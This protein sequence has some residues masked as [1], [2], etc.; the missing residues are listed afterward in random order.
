MCAQQTDSQSNITI[1]SRYTRALKLLRR[2]VRTRLALTGMVIVVG[3][4]LVAVFADFI[5]PHPPAEQYHDAVRHPPSLDPLYPFGTDQYGRDVF[6]RVVYGSRY[7]LFLGIVIVSIQMAF[8]VTLGLIAGYYKDSYIEGAIMRLVDISL[9]IPDI[10]LA[11]AIAGVL[12]GGLIPLIIAV[13][14]VGWR[15][16]GRLVRGDVRTI[17]EDDYVR[18]AQM[19]GVSDVSIMLR[20]VLPNAIDSVIVF[21]TLNIPTVILYAA[22]LSFLGL[23]VNP[24]TPEWGALIADGRG[25]LQQAW[26]IS[27]FPGLAIMV[28]VIGFNV[29]GDGLR[30]AVDPRQAQL[31]ESE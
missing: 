16:F 14:A 7:A 5:A 13:S 8:G 15:G 21:A 12:G 27:T 18:A 25:D 6:S 22:G 10:V 11:L 20:H 19:S 23:G 9:S 1:A 29:I 3:L 31:G 2:S 24:P 30:E 4:V 28:T 26:W 17:M